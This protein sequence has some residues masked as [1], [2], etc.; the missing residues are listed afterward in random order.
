MPQNPSPSLL[1][2]SQVIERTFDSADDALRVNVI[3]GNIVVS[4]PSVGTNGTT[5]PTSSNLAGGKDGSGNLQPLSTD[6]SGNLNVNVGT[7]ALPTG[8]S[9]SAKQD[10]G[11]ASLASIDS[12]L[13]NPLPISASSLPLPSGAATAANQSTANTS[14]S[15][16]DGKT[17]ALGQALAAASVPVVLTAAQL[18]TLTPL[19]SVSVSNFPATQPIS[20]TVT[21][22][23]LTNSSI[24]K[25]QVQDNSGNGITSTSNALDINIKSGSIANTSFASTQSGT[26]NIT[27]VSGTVSLPT[28]ASTAAK[29]PALGTAGTASSDVITV[30]G[31]ASMT[32]LKVDGSA[33]TQPVSG[34]VTANAGTGTFAV[35]GTVTANAGTNL[36][37]S[38]LALESGGNLASIKTDVDNLSLSQASTT[39]GQKGN[40]T[41]T[42]TTTSAPTYV[43][44]QSN[45]LSTTTSGALR[46]DLGA[47]TANTTAIKVDGSAV[48]QPVSIAGNQAVNVAQINGVTPLMGN[49]TSGTGAQ[50]VVIASDNTAFSVNS[51]LQAGTNLV[52][53]VGIDQTTP[54][55]TN[56]VSLAQIGANTVLTGN[57]VTGTGSQRVTIASDNTAF[58]VNAA[59]SGAWTV[60]PGNTANTTAWLTTQPGRTTANT[61]AYND[62]TSTAVTTAAY[63]QLIASTTSATGEVEIFDSSGQ[64]L[65]LAV[66]GAGSEVD[67]IFIFPGGNGRV[68]LK[69]AASSRISIKAK[70]AT[71]N[72]GFIMLNLYT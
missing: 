61:S 71:A 59:Q 56:A 16:I 25:A 69:I 10:T 67:Q 46:I 2:S 33:T 27:N 1:S 20:G 51:N 7:L 40:L 41:L 72:A 38:L 62:Y 23:P 49:G 11:N 15:S 14:L 28:G 37:T 9:T 42:A 19:S 32:A 50:R 13:T 48:T 68:P 57:G 36:N 4:N 47:T 55:T 60:Q 63:T 24:V 45:P 8:A 44:A 18:S 70:T 29:Q 5:A 43:T 35:S 3:T 22:N 31:I 58:T 6:S 65:I 66:G 12:K 30:Q 54:G 52:G 17:P 39:S 34:T 64:G 53:K 26:W 21:V